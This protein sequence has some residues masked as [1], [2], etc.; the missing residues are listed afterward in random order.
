VLAAAVEAA[1]PVPAASAVVV[2]VVAAAAA[3]AAM[4]AG[5]AL[6]VDLVLVPACKLHGSRMLGTRSSG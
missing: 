6:R 1:A 3:A 2:V 4:S 5:P